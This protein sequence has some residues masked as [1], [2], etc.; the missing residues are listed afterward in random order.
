MLR[1]FRDCD[2]IFL[3][4]QKLQCA[5]SKCS[6][7]GQLEKLQKLSLRSR[8]TSCS[9]VKCQDTRGRSSSSKSS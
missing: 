7:D 6:S 2:E 4:N 9:L 3:V 1:H 5:S 8:P